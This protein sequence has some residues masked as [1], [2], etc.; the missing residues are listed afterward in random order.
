MVLHIL[1]LPIINKNHRIQEL[2]YK[3]ETGKYN[4]KQN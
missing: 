2:E 3:I 4:K 1:T